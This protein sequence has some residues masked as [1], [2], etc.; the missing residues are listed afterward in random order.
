LPQFEPLFFLKMTLSKFTYRYL[1]EF[2]IF[3]FIISGFWSCTDEPKISTIPIISDQAKRVDAT[4]GIL[5]SLRYLPL[6]T[7]SDCLI[8]EVLKLHCQGDKIYVLN[9][10]HPERTLLVFNVEGNFIFKVGNTEGPGKVLR[11]NDF[12]VDE[13]TGNIDLLDSYQKKLIRFDG[14]GKYLTTLTTRHPFDQMRK[15]PSG[16]YICYSG[17]EAI[18]GG[19][20]DLIHLTGNDFKIEASF[21]SP[22]LSN[23][24]SSMGATFSNN[25]QYPVLY[26]Q[27][28]SKTVWQIAEKNVKPFTTIDF[29]DS[30]I[31]EATLAKMESIEN[32]GEK[33]NFLNGSPFVNGISFFDI[34]GDCQFFTYYQ[35][36]KLYWNLFN[37]VSKNLK[38]ISL[39]YDQPIANGIDGGMMPFAP[40]T[41]LGDELVFL[42]EPKQ[43]FDFIN[44]Q[45]G[46]QQTPQSPAM[47]DLLKRIQPNDNAIVVFVKL[48]C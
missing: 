13:A 41:V 6:E 44:Q 42:M 14:A 18:E 36:G 7:K 17:D 2:L 21:I 33:V 37:P 27:R 47:N 29:G 16:G 30:W 5:Q 10:I 25:Q 32:P 48:K 35:K 43:L 46:G 20:G 23:Y 15:L 26:W 8:S 12:S 11:C 9:N 34:V 3:L 24:P 22:A 31:D 19:N 45:S 39:K 38:S 40:L 4:S 28:F 1:L